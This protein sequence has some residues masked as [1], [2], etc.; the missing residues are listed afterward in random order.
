MARQIR[1]G[2]LSYA[3]KSRPVA[4]G[5]MRPFACVVCH[6]CAVVKE[7]LFNGPAKKPDRLAERFQ[8]E[9]WEFDAFN[10]NGITCPDCLARRAAARRGESGRAAK[11]RPVPT[12]SEGT[13]VTLHLKPEAGTVL[14]PNKTELTVEERSRVRDL[15]LGTF[16]E[17]AGQYSEGWSDLRVADEAGGV[18]P[19][20]VADLR[21]IAFGPLRAVVELE[22]LQARLGAVDGRVETLLR[23]LAGI[24]DE[25][26]KL[27][28]SIADATK[29]LGVR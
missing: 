6:A 27:R 14:P 22:P 16:D 26:A 2:G 4:G 17:K 12:P 28:A 20:L 18:P 13:V 5:E 23:E 9:G 15:L 10:A 7:V 1:H 19:K 24:Q 3:I 21:E 8:D 25:Q 29:R 11:S